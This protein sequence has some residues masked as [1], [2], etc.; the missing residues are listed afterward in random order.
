M[1]TWKMEFV[2]NSYWKAGTKHE[3]LSIN[4]KKME[5]YDL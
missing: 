3:I 4:G 5:R 2:T 1:K